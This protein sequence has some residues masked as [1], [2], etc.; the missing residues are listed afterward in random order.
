MNTFRFP[1]TL[2]TKEMYTVNSK[3]HF[4]MCYENS[5][6]TIWFRTQFSHANRSADEF[7]SSSTT[8]PFASL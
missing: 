4:N 1:L 7:P 5:T 8:V 6:C 2:I 3:Q